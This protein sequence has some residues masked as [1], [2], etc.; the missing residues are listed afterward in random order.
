MV[1]QRE[2]DGQVLVECDEQRRQERRGRD[3][4]R[5]ELL[6]EALVGTAVERTRDR[7]PAT[8][9]RA[10]EVQTDER[11]ENQGREEV[12]DQQVAD[13]PESSDHLLFHF[14]FTFHIFFS[15]LPY[16]PLSS[17]Q[18]FLASHFRTNWLS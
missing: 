10:E 8:T 12:D 11:D 5:R 18:T 4:R 7:L 6:Q 9:A 15:P 14:F 1:S 3:R 2:Q 17:C 16:K 13:E